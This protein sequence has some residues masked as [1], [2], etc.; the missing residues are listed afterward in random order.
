ML[1]YWFGSVG[2]LPALDTENAPN[3]SEIAVILVG[4]AWG[5]QRYTS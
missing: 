4:K 1:Q 3:L 2:W 5:S